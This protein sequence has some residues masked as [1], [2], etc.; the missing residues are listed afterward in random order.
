MTSVQYRQTPPTP[1]SVSRTARTSITYSLICTSLV[2][3]DSSLVINQLSSSVTE[4][5]SYEKVE[6]AVLGSPSLTVL[7]VSVDLKATFKADDEAVIRAQ[8]LCESRGG[9]PVLPVPDSPYG[10]YGRK[11]TLN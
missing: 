10:L 11:A 3:A 4:P 1:K 6:V 2:T 7:M 9:R 5:I 8:E